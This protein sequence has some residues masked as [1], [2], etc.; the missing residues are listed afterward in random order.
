[1]VVLELIFVF[2][3]SQPVSGVRHPA[4]FRARQG[5]LLAWEGHAVQEW[6]T[7]KC[8]AVQRRPRVPSSSCLSFTPAVSS[9]SQSSLGKVGY[10]FMTLTPAIH[11]GKGTGR[12]FVLDLWRTSVETKGQKE[13]QT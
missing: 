12:A 6:N 5:E 13:A 11:L 3:L 7:R 10:F 4:G 8:T 1:M 2:S 9:S